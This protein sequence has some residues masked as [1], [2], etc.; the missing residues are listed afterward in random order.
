MTNERHMMYLDVT[1][2]IDRPARTF[3]LRPVTTYSHPDG[4]SQE[5]GVVTRYGPVPDHL[6]LDFVA[7]SIAQEYLDMFE[8]VYENTMARFKI[9][10]V[11]RDMQGARLC[12]P[13]DYG[14]MTIQQKAAL[15]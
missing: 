15:K 13:S 12:P 1:V 7:E 14:K 4:S 5:D 11:P 9:G 6:D 3:E 10:A 2:Q 8:R